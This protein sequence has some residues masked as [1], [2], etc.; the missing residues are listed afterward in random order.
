MCSKELIPGAPTALAASFHHM[1][2]ASASTYDRAL[3]EV[4]MVMKLTGK[5]KANSLLGQG[6]ES[7]HVDICLMLPNGL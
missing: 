6:R 2:S 5:E 7:G 1:A 3:W 4:H